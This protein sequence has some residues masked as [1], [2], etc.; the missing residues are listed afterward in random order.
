MAETT[1]IDIRNVFTGGRSIDCI[2]AAYF[3]SIGRPPQCMQQKRL[4]SPINVPIPFSQA[5]NTQNPRNALCS[6][7]HPRDSA[8]H[9]RR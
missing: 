1:Q 4:T 6:V 8:R 9:R 5:G 3:L 7:A 2:R